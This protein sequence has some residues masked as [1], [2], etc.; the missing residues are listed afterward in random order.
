MTCVCGTPVVGLSS[1]F[2]ERVVKT[3]DYV[4]YE[5][6]DRQRKRNRSLLSFPPVSG[7][8]TIEPTMSSVGH[9]VL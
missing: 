9:V 5:H 2:I 7:P 1:I 6:Q 8:D 4:R 3:L